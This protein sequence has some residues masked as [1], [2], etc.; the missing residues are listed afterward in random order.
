MTERV[1]LGVLELRFHL[2][3][4]RSLKDKRQRLNGLRDR[5]GRLPGVAVC[6]SDRADDLRQAVWSFVAVGAS[7][8]AVIKQLDGI[9]RHASE[10]IDAQ[11]VERHREML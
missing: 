8:S 4:C 10:S 2:P 7:R 1:H 9:E 3:G 11:I 5:F 6:E